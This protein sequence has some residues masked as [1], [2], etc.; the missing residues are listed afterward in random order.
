MYSKEGKGYGTVGPTRRTSAGE[1]G[2]A[3]SGS[4]AEQVSVERERR[5][6]TTT[7][8]NE[9]LRS[10]ESP[11][12]GTV[13]QEGF[14]Y[15]VQEESPGRGASLRRISRETGSHQVQEEVPGASELPCVGT[16]IPTSTSTQSHSRSHT[17]LKVQCRSEVKWNYFVYLDG[18]SVHWAM[19]KYIHVANTVRNG[20][21]G[22]RYG[23][24][25]NTVT[26]MRR[27]Q[28]SEKLN[29]TINC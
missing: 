2:G 4:P 13:E 19:H 20:K 22:T 24:T 6:A 28:C 25:H 18:Y 9:R 23:Q 10:V 3:S 14:S 26:Y 8:C 5:K 21:R 12:V 1:Q 29:C 17:V 11:C 16:A 7:K 15:Q 27:H